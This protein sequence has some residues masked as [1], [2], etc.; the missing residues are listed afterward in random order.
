MINLAKGH[1]IS[2][3]YCGN[4]LKLKKCNDEDENRCYQCDC[5]ICLKCMTIL[6]KDYKFI[7]NNVLCKKCRMFC[8]NCQ[9]WAYT[10]HVDCSNCDARGVSLVDG[11][12]YECGE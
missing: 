1:K 12:C 2:L 3:I 6:D 9:L 8:Q 11:K 4:C 10:G 7:Y 5:E